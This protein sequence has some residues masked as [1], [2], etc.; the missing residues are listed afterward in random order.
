[1]APTKSVGANIPPGAPEEKERVVAMIFREDEQ[2]EEVPDELPVHRLV[3]E[4][5][6]RAH[7]LRNPDAADP[8]HQARSRR[9]PI[10]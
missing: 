7:H 9:K 2:D 6:S 3:H 10:L 1:M 4:I 8:D 5:V